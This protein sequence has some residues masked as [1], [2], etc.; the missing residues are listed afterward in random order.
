MH[1]KI[2]NEPKIYR[3]QVLMDDYNELNI[4]IK[5]HLYNIGD[6]EFKLRQPIPT[7]QELDKMLHQVVM[8]LKEDSKPMRLIRNS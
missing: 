4:R 3:H 5:T 8:A 2:Y 1:R 6:A 7:M